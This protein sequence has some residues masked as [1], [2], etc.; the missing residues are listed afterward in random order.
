[1]EIVTRFAPVMELETYLHSQSVDAGYFS[2]SR[3]IQQDERAMYP[4]EEISA[5]NDW[6]L[7]HHLV[8]H[9]LGGN[10]RDFDV[11]MLLY[12][13]VFRRDPAIGFAYGVAPFMAALPIWCSGSA[14]QKRALADFVLSGQ[15]ICLF[16]P[17]VWQDEETD[18]EQFMAIE[19]IDGYRISGV[20][21]S[22]PNASRS[23]KFVCYAIAGGKE[24]ANRYSIFLLSSSHFHDAELLS[25]QRNSQT[26]LRSCLMNDISAEGISVE[27]DALVGKPRSGLN[28]LARSLNVSRVIFPGVMIGVVEAAIRCAIGFLTQRHLYRTYVTELPLVRSQLAELGT[29][30]CI[31]DILTLTA[32]RS[33]HSGPA[34]SA[35]TSSITGYYVMTLLEECFHTASVLLG[36]R[37]FLRS[38]EHGYFQKL[39]RD[40]QVASVAYHDKTACL[41]QLNHELIQAAKHWF[42]GGEKEASGKAGLEKLADRFSFEHPLSVFQ[43]AETLSEGYLDD[44]L[45]Q[46]L[47]GILESLHSD[48]PGVPDAAAAALREV[49]VLMRA[50]I[51]KHD[52]VMSEVYSHCHGSSPARAIEPYGKQYCRLYSSVCCFY[53]WY[54]NRNAP[55]PHLQRT[56]WL[57]SSLK[58]LADPDR[59]LDGACDQYMSSTLLQS[60]QQNLAFSVLG[61]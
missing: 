29:K 45:F 15:T 44:L 7:Q 51:E 13:V 25:F 33:V 26:A 58:L 30:L 28:T 47:S 2:Q 14:E 53:T 41:V 3:A 52:R 18:D 36:A 32:A 57:I 42:T 17:E 12:R 19:S 20:A 10:L 37:H 40:F 60:C 27:H 35:I 9:E 5:L 6:T 4:K 39:L 21:R 43:W 11:M 34:H 55:F 54:F 59:V 16:P 46:P 49:L 23:G 1:M 24:P 50:V 31:A 48:L 61:I 56:E 38:G 22:V 8:P